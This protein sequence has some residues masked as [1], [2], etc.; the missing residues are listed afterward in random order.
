MNYNFHAHTVL[1]NHAT[2]TQREYIEKAIECGIKR[3]GFSEHIP[4]KFPD[5]HESSHRCSVNDVEKYISETNKLKEEYK[6][7]IELHVGFEI[8]YSP[9]YFSEM[10]NNAKKWGAEYL[11]L[12]QH[13][14]FEEYPEAIWSITETNDVSRLKEYVKC[15]IEAMKSGVITYVAHPDIINFKGSKEIYEEEMR[16]ICKASK[17]TDVPLEINLLGIRDKRN[18]PYMDFWKIAGEE[19]S[20]VVF[21]FDAHDVDGAGDMNS[22]LIAEK[23]VSEYNL[24]LKNNVKLKAI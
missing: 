2:G 7:K 21:G 16:K 15:V 19:K 4:F 10:V 20:P 22:L 1:C 5:G 14:V 11:I 23:I 24:N 8:E 6:D 3:M 17:E 13:F 12:G 9:K 18:Y